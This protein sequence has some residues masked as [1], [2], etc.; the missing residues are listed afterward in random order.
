M[1]TAIDGFTL[2]EMLVVITI[3]GT[4]LTIG[5]PTMRGVRNIA[6]DREAKTSLATAQYLARSVF[7]DTGSYSNASYDALAS[8]DRTVTFVSAATAS[9]GGQVVSVNATAPEWSAVV[10]SSSGT[11]FRAQATS[12]AGVVIAPSAWSTGTCAAASLPS[13]STALSLPV[14][15]AA[16]WLDGFDL[17]GDGYAEGDNENC[18]ASSNCG[19]TAGAASRWVDK[20]SLAAT[21]SAASG[22]EPVFVQDV[23][24]GRGAVR[25]DGN[26]DVLSRAS[27]AFTSV[28]GAG[29][30]VTVFVVQKAAAAQAGAVL[31]L[32][33]ADPTHM[34][35]YTPFSDSGVYFDA[36][37]SASARLVAAAQGGVVGTWTELSARRNG[38]TQEL[39]NNQVRIASATSASGTA[40][41]SATFSVG[42]STASSG[43]WSGDIGEIIVYPTA[44]TDTQRG[45]VE[46][47]LAAKWSLRLGVAATSATSTTAPT[48]TVAATT[49][50]AAATT[51]TAPATTQ[52]A[53]SVQ[54][55][56]SYQVGATI[57]ATVVGKN[58]SGSVVTTDNTTAV[59][60]SLS[61][62]PGGATLSCSNPGGLTH[63]LSSGSASFT[64]T[65]DK[66]GAS[67]AL[68]AASGVLTPATS[69]S[70]DSYSPLT[71][72]AVGSPTGR[73]SS[74]TMTITYPTGV[75]TNDLLLLVEVNSANQAIT[76][77][78]GWTLLTDDAT[79]S[80]SQCRVTVWQRLAGTESSVD[81]SV[82]TNSSG[83][84]A[85]VIDYARP[86]SYP[87]NP[88]T[89]TATN[90][91][92]LNTAASTMTPSSSVTTSQTYAT[93]VSIAAIRAGN[94]LSLSTAQGFTL[95]TALTFTPG[96]GQAVAIGIADQV[97]AASGST[98]TSPTWSQ[99]GTAAQWAWSTVAYG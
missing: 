13:A 34:L 73:T 11:C 46:G 99:S 12:A 86:I 39:F 62:N 8:L 80:P 19:A 18:S 52:L 89:A 14:T 87:P 88:S 64:C 74:G 35:M 78:S 6:G 48:T 50:T 81:L 25:F 59:T 56:S 29:Q 21:V 7:A 65:I 22:A 92:G 71:F 17:D 68:G 97:V 41:G 91:S 38:V 76:T 20:G 60:L 95:Q 93:V 36:Y 58:S 53:F 77:P 40:G 23:I 63:T 10:L 42:A 49:T 94:T 69:S 32:G 96:S 9:T 2:L 16:I 84:S 4:L 57:S 37:G 85:W 43:Y 51:T 79:S 26:S 30:D 98:P 70:F 47:Y 1:A 44:L 5:L 33:S 72:A 31:A 90:Q 82:H 28:M 66:T 55:S 54:P 24:N 83:A 75:A 27:V 15:G 67:Y 61:T 3:M 45:Q